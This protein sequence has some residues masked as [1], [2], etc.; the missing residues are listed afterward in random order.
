VPQISEQDFRFHNDAA[1]LSS[2]EPYKFLVKLRN[3]TWET[4]YVIVSQNTLGMMGR[5]KLRLRYILSTIDLT[6]RRAPL[7]VLYYPYI[8]PTNPI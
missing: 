7:N 6:P 1:P 8:I 4:N 5:R 3:I 2:A